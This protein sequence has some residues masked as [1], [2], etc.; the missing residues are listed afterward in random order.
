MWSASEELHEYTTHGNVLEF[1]DTVTKTVRQSSDLLREPLGG[2]SLSRSDD[3]LEEIASVPKFST[4]QVFH[5][6]RHCFQHEWTKTIACRRSAIRHAERLTPNAFERIRR[7]TFD[8]T[9]RRSAAGNDCAP[10]VLKAMPFKGMQVLR[11][12]SF[13]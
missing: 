6:Q 5:L 12:K 11:L 4:H 7:P 10:F 1:V 8:K 2:C 3:C 13:C 9:D